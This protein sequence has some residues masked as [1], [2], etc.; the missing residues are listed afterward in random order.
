M[1]DARILLTPGHMARNI[2]SMQLPPMLACT[3]YLRSWRQYLIQRDQNKCNFP[4]PDT[5]EVLGQV[6]RGKDNAETHQAIA[7]RLKVH[8]RE[9][10]SPK[11]VRAT[12]G[13]VM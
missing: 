6:R 12:T 13:K 1:L 11:L 5:M 4:V 3:P 2:T 9:P 10:H 8:H 7:P